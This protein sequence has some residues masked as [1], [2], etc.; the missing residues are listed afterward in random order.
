[1]HNQNCSYD[2]QFLYR[3]E[4]LGQSHTTLLH[5]ERLC[6]KYGPA[7]PNG[8]KFDGMVGL[9]TQHSWMANKSLGLGLTLTPVT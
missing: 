9:K 6:L 7:R 8:L 2:R 3:S 4:H 1:M 5:W